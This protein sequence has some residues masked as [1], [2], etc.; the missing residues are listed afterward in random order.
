MSSI[1]E[2][3]KNLSP[4]E[5]EHQGIITSAK[6]A[7]TY[8][9]PVCGNGSG[10]DGDGL[11]VKEYSWGYNYHCFKEGKNYTAVDLIKAAY[12][13]DEA[14]VV[15]IA[16]EKFGLEEEKS[17]KF[18]TFYG[19]NKKM[20]SL[21]VS[22]GTATDDV[23]KNYGEKFYPYAQNQ[24]EGFLQNKGGKFRGLEL[25]DLR[26]VSSGYAYGKLILP[27]DDYH[28]FEREVKGKGKKYIKGRREMYNPYCVDFTSPVIVTE[29]EIDCL[30]IHKATGLPCVAVGSA[31]N[32][33]SLVGWLND[34]GFIEKLEKPRLILIGDNNDDGTGQ[35][36]V[37]IG[38]EELKK[39]G[40]AAVSFILSTA[41]KYD[42]NEWLQKD[43]EGLTKR[44][45]E[46]YEKASIELQELVTQIMIE[47]EIKENGGFM[48]AND[49]NSNLFDKELEELKKVSRR[50]SGYGNIDE[51][52]EFLPG[53]YFVGA[54]SSLGKTSF[55]LQWAEQMARLGETVLFCSYEMSLIELHSK[56]LAR[57]VYLKNQ[58]TTLTATQIRRGGNDADLKAVRQELN[59]K[60]LKIAKF[61]F[62]T[63]DELIEKLK[64]AMEK[65][66]KAPVI[67]I[68][69]LQ[70]IRPSK[71]LR[72]TSSKAAIDDIVMKLKIF[73]Q[74]TNA[75]I[76][77][78]SSFNRMN[79]TQTA[80]FESFKESGGVEYT[81]DV[82]F[83]L[84]LYC[85]AELRGT[86]TSA[87]DDRKMIDLAKKEYPRK[88]RLKCLKNRV[89]GLYDCFFK[90]Y[91]KN[92]YF[93]ACT[94]GELKLQTQT[95]VAYRS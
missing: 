33:K 88:I 24:L 95:K 50:K 27:Y 85:T 41:E 65:M 45:Y 13:I 8:I 92:D 66:E 56:V 31:V 39:A 2:Q 26:E 20:E 61:N 77:V 44:L 79:Y 11:T 57:N 68:D 58:Y 94:E 16:K 37:A 25:K 81:A 51:K 5:L 19:N 74:E 75:I 90:F 80:A 15:E 69:Y 60:N 82:L 17:P 49:Y 84:E 63:I 78:V 6:V 72:E 46:I 12:G 32:F 40:Y 93:E 30:S 71:E 4:T 43:I 9:C 21:V 86:Q 29:G 87:Q 35:K 64:M 62:E 36:Q 1:W 52:Q 47:D 18:S 76:V 67:F 10:K 89:G 54:I 73:Q 7:G 59:L 70:F 3:I 28:Y 83:A 14:G 22:G 48:N 55:C 38:L 34:L 42:A 91:M 23:P 53:L